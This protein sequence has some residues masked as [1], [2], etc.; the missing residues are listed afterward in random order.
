MWA[1]GR[2]TFSFCLFP[3]AACL[4]WAGGCRNCD[5][6]EAELRS[7]DNNLRELRADL[8]R[9]EAHNEAL[10]REL[11]GIRQGTV[12]KISPEF[13]SQT[14][15][16]KQITLGRGTGGVDEDDC[17]GDDALQIAL[18]P[19][20]GD[21]HTIKAPGAV[22]IEAWEFNPEGLKTLLSTWD[23]SP[24]QL[25]QTW[26]SGL[27]S[28]GYL[29]KLPWKNWPSFE[30]LRVV[31]RFTLVDGRVFEADKD[32]AIRLTPAAHRKP[33]LPPDPAGATPTLEPVPELP[34]PQKVEPKPAGA[35]NAWW[36]LPADSAVTAKP[37]SGNAAQP[38][39]VWRP[40]A[41]P[42]VADSVQL[43]RPVSLK[44][45]PGEEP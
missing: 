26:H 38:A 3:F 8:A 16:L 42:S 21:G 12:T 32:V 20:D 17:P 24:E 5:L 31:V 2:C 25:R 6:V 29:I 7:R 1:R 23:L 9:A 35:S 18:E 13:A 14:Y 43:L 30:K 40:K 4:L 22:H 45:Q 41:V 39:F 10:L 37:A 28:T 19:R 44:S 15:T 34:P 36:L 11:A 33:I 27:L